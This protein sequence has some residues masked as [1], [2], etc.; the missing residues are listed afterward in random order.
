V[1][2]LSVKIGPSSHSF[3]SPQL[4]TA[5]NAIAGIDPKQLR[6]SSSR[7]S[8]QINKAPPNFLVGDKQAV[9][10]DFRKVD[11]ELHFD[12]ATR[13]TTV[14]AKVKFF[15]KSKG[16]P[17]LDLNND[18]DSISVNGTALRS[19]DLRGV[20][21]PDDQSEL[22]MIDA[23]LAPGE[24]TAELSYTLPQDKTISYVN[25]GVRMHTNFDDLFKGEFSERWF[26]SNLE[27]DQYKQNIKLTISGSD[28]EHLVMSNGA[29]SKQEN[30]SYSIDFP[31]YFNTAAF[32]LE[33]VDPS[34]YKVQEDVYSGINGD[35][36]LKLY[37]RV[38]SQL[39]RGITILKRKMAQMER[40]FGAFPHAKFVGRID[41]TF[42]GG[43]EYAGATVT[44]LGALEHEV[45]HSWFARGMMPMDGNS[46][47]M[48]EALA[49]WGDK[50]YR[51]ARSVGT[52]NGSQMSGFSP[53]RR[54]TTFSAY[55]DGARLMSELDYIFKDQGGLKAQMRDFYGANV[56]QTVSTQM[57]VDF[58]EPRTQHNIG[59]LFRRKVFHRPADQERT[60]RV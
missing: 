22:R 25:G 1:L 34:R 13:R 37:G 58:L 45:D 60:P 29:V 9:F 31:E 55:S 41:E 38:N 14:K 44:T 15:Q 43:M 50:G 6:R 16:R 57:F 48:D 35:I 24:H 27:Y 21:D 56:R 26:P 47:W 40:D 30:G 42:P 51:R 7:R 53:Y 28:R 39:T 5:Q 23:E 8:A 11:V 49:S 19:F 59:E 3:A 10:V 32:Y 12:A 54:R 46:G 4:S 52:S 36:P 18:V 33:V 2:E 17:L 20:R